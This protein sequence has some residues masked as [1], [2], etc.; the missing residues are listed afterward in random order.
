MEVG[1]KIGLLAAVASGCV[2]TVITTL[3]GAVSKVVGG[4]NASLYEHFFA[5][6]IA[7]VAIGIMLARGSMDRDAAIT[8]IPMSAIVGVLVLGAVAAIAFAIPRTGV[9]VGNFALVFGQ[10][11]FAVVLDTI[12]VGGLDRV[13][14]TPQRILGLVIM[15]AGIYL[16]LPK[17]G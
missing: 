13:P 8:V 17:E 5:G 4:I 3:E 7:I 12:G 11:V 9:M 15:V 16:V 2:F 10:L 1:L 14:L 6:I